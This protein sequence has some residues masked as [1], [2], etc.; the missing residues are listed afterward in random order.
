M[1][2]VS[3]KLW[4][5]VP[6]MVLAI[7]MSLSAWSFI[8]SEHYRK[9]TDIIFT[10]TYEVRWRAFQITEKLSNIIEFL[11]LSV[12]TEEE[13]M[14]LA[15]EIRLLEFS[16][17]ALKNLRYADIFFEI[18]DFDRIIKSLDTIK[19]KIIPSLLIDSG[20]S[21]ILNWIYEIRQDMSLVSDTAGAQGRILKE[22]NQI[23]QG[24]LRNTAIFALALSGFI[25]VGVII[26]QRALFEERKDQQNRSFSS[27]FAHMTRSRISGLALFIGNLSGTEALTPKSLPR[28]L[29]QRRSWMPSTADS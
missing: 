25:V 19:N 22:I 16:I 5:L 20:R 8:Q 10:Q 7:A 24:A 17:T 2:K 26:R 11:K 6:Y 23:E 18:R 15:Q 13:N 14:H 27:L 21:S 9:E 1:I 12:E 4:R 3:R 29:A 28:H